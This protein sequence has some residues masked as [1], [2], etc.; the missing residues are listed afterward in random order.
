MKT[1][2]TTAIFCLLGF[3]QT[4]KACDCFFI[5]NFCEAI[6]F[7]NNGQVLDY[8][9]VYR[10][11][12]T[13]TAT[14]GL[15]V[16]VGETYAGENKTGH[17]LFIEDGNGANCVLFASSNLDLNSTYI[18]AASAWGDTLSLSDCAVSF[19]EVVDGQVVGAIAPGVSEVALVDFPNTANCGNLSPT[20]T[21]DPGPLGGIFV[22][23]TLAKDF[24]EIKTLSLQAADLEVAVYDATGR[25][26]QEMDVPDFGFYS[27]VNLDMKNWANGVYF[28]RLKIGGEISTQRV[29][30]TGGD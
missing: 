21:V 4:A 1:T 29:L 11:K 2:V 22:R 12:V 30:K 7:E 8:L 25:L 26:V 28:L 10:V 3:A 19:L 20:S 5:N 23:P 18:I 14:N 13:A 16:F 15:K 6:T 27:D 24:V 17:N 9:N